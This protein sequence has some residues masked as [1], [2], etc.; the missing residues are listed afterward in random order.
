MNSSYALWLSLKKLDLLKDSPPY[1]WP[2]VGTFDV[3]VGAILTQ[4]TKWEKVEEALQNLRDMDI[5]SLNELSNAPIMII[6]TAIK[7]CSYYKKK[8]LTLQAVCMAIVETFGDFETFKEEVDRAWLLD[9]K[10]IGPE[11]GDAIL[12]YAC[13]R[14]IM[15]VDSYTNR[16]LKAYGYTFESYDALQEWIEFGIRE[17]FSD[18]SKNDM[19][20]ESLFTIFSRFHGMIVEYTKRNVHKG[21]VR[22]DPLDS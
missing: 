7:P 21:K 17:R 6:Q 22:T 3:V 13:K 5:C 12:C 16:L 10:G 9:Q 20:C 2:D 14:D 1:W 8:S 4:Q 19:N 18:I 15:V 11:S